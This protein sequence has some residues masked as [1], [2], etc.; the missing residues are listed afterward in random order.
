MAMSDIEAQPVFRQVT[1]LDSHRVEVSPLMKKEWL[2]EMFG[3]AMRGQVVIN[4]N[5]CDHFAMTVKKTKKG[6]PFAH[7]GNCWIQ[8]H[9]R[10]TVTMRWFENQAWAAV[11]R[12]AEKRA[13]NG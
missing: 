11:E 9:L 5:V 1:Q 10:S 7:C 2:K 3:A 12:A 8:Y 6:L 13:H 4:C